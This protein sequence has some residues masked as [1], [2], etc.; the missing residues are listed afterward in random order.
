MQPKPGESFLLDGAT[1]TDQ[2]LLIVE[3][4]DEVR[5]FIKENLQP[6]Y[7]IL[8]AEDGLKGLSLATSA[9]P[10]VI[11][12]DI[13]MPGLDGKELCEKLKKDERTSHIPLIMLTARATTHDKIEGLECGADDYIFKPFSMEEI[14]TRICNLLQQ[15]ERL[16]LKYSGYIGLDWNKITVTTLDEEFLKKTTGII[17]QHLHEFEFDVG[18]LQEEMAISNS[19][20]Y[21]KLKVLTGESPNSLIRIMRLKRAASLLEKNESSITEI[22]MSVGFSNPSYFTRCFKAYFGVTPREYQRPFN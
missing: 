4:N 18:A 5:S 3:D 12:S 1:G 10:D 11:I 13:M 6:N 8:E 19:T 20:L 7:K 9:I 15:R 16:R 17:S 14:E 21:K 2:T 22:L